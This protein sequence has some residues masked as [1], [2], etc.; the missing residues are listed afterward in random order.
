MNAANAPPPSRRTLHFTSID[1]VL[2]EAD[3]LVEAA[4][5]GQVSYAG[6]WTLATILNHLAIWAEFAYNGLPLKIPLLLRLLVR[7]FKGRILKGAMPSGRRLPN[8]PGGTLG[9]EE[10]PL[11]KAHQRLQIA[12]L[13]LK[14]DP[15]I[16]A[17]PLLGKLTHPQWIALHLRHAELH[18]SFVLPP[19]PVRGS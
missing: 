3:R 14:N 8:V 15:P 16:L 9:I 6:R 13:R 4:C 17:H 11:G 10:I 1:N 7:P 5:A 2:A 12:F 18:L 19:A